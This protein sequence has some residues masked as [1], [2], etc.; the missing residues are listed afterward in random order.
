MAREIIKNLEKARRLAFKNFGTI[1]FEPEAVEILVRAFLHPGCKSDINLAKFLTGKPVSL[2]DISPH[3]ITAFPSQAARFAQ[4]KGIRV[5]TGAD[6]LECY[7]LDHADAIE[8]NLEHLQMQPAYALAHLLTIGTAKQCRSVEQ[9]QLADIE[10]TVTGARVKFSHVLVPRELT[11][12]VGSVVFHHF[13]VVLAVASTPV[14]RDLARSLQ[15]R[16]NGKA[17]V[18]KLSRQVFGKN[19]DYAKESFFRVD[20]A[21]KI[22]EQSKL[23]VDFQ[24]LWQEEDLKKIKFPK[25]AKVI[26]QS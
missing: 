6:L 17:F 21:G 20:M 14:L 7:A 16:Q 26:F 9:R 13:G 3:I 15:R 5:I 2:T 8:E 24:R 10:V 19:I 22:I 12:R 23:G 25:E 11:V 1:I 4:R 18:Q